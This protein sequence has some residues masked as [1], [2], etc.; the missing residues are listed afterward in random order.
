MKRLKPRNRIDTLKSEIRPRRKRV[1]AR[2]IY[3]S[4]LTFLALWLFDMMAGPLFY[5]QAEGMISRDLSVVMP[6]YTGTVKSLHVERGD[7]VRVDQPIA[8]LRSREMLGDIVRS[9]TQLADLQAQMSG[10]RIRQ[11]SD[12]TLIP[13]ARSRVADSQLASSSLSQLASSGLV[14]N[15][16]RT[17][18]NAEAFRALED[19]K[20]LETGSSLVESEIVQVAKSVNRAVRALDEIEDIYRDGDFVSPVAGIVG[21][22]SVSVGSVVKEGAPMVEVFHGETYVLAYIP[23]GALYQV[24]AGDAVSLRYGFHALEG[25]VEAI[26]PLAHRLPQEFQKTFDTAQREQLVRIT[27]VK[28]GSFPP[29]FTKVSISW[30]WTPSA[31]LARA[32]TAMSAS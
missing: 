25:R 22:I 21:S 31:L 14:T 16:D 24:T 4:L 3:L 27:L 20:R 19:L 18:A 7:R 10:M 15:R 1:L 23:V 30:A 2:N 28:N 11:G 6:E 9:S 32:I 17:L 8:R 26:L 29:L 12:K 5:L 13:A